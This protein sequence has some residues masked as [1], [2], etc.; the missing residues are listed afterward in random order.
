M[1]QGFYIEELVVRAEL[2]HET[3]ERECKVADAED[4]TTTH[5]AKI[6]S[7]RWNAVGIVGNP[8]RPFKLAYNVAVGYGRDL[9]QR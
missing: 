8:M 6:R 5:S 1:R 4:R 9:Q 2:G 3:Y 7:W